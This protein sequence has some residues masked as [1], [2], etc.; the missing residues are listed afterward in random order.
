MVRGEISDPRHPPTGAKLQA[1]MIG[2]PL[3]K[4]AV[5]WALSET[6]VHPG[7]WSVGRTLLE[8]KALEESLDSRAGILLGAA[9]QGRFMAA[10]GKVLFT[11]AG[12]LQIVAKAAA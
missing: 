2:V 5:A 9:L 11:A 4:F 8:A 1:G 10:V 3:R 12:D 6:R 7:I